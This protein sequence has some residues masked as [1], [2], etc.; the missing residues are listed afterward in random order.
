MACGAGTEKPGHDT[1][2]EAVEALRRAYSAHDG[3]AFLACVDPHSRKSL[4]DAYFGIPKL[5]AGGPTEQA[6]ISEAL[7]IAPE[8]SN[9]GKLFRLI[10]EHDIAQYWFAAM[11]GGLECFKR[12]DPTFAYGLVFPGPWT[13]EEVVQQDEATAGAHVSLRSGGHEIHV[14]MPLCRID[15]RWYA[16]GPL[17]DEGG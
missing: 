17:P 8:K 1:P 14:L 10:D 11:P 2:G 16:Q 13:L 3:E 12:L 5:L 6:W 15:G 4:V 7:E 9:L